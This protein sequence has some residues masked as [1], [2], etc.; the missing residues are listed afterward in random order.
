[1]SGRRRSRIAREHP[2]GTDQ[3]SE[4]LG[5]A[6]GLARTSGGITVPLP[7]HHRRPL[8]NVMRAPCAAPPSWRQQSWPSGCPSRP[9]PPV[10]PPPPRPHRLPPTR[11]VPRP[12]PPT[13]GPAPG[14]S[15][16]RAAGPRT[17]SR[18]CGRSCTPASAARRRGC[19]CPTRSAA[20]PLVVADV[21]VAQRTSGSTM[22]DRHRPRG[23]LRRPDLGHHAG[24]RLAVSD[25]IAFTVTALSDVAVSFYLPQPTGPATYHQQG[26]QTN[27]VAAGDV[28][29]NATLS[30]AATTGSYSFLTNLD[31]QN[32]AA[33]GRGRH[34]RRVDHRRRRLRAGQQPPLAQ[35]PG[36]AAVRQPAAPSACSTRAS[37]AT[38]CSADGAGQSALNRFDRDVLGQP[39][40]R[41]V[42]FSDDPINDLGSANPAQRRPAHRRPTA[43]DLPRAPGGGCR[44]CARR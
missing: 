14:R 44:S 9:P 31:V 2:P 12:P 32:A 15:R 5:A 30:G 42:I 27:Y 13:A 29:G 38:S 28:S 11:P 10:R 25:S 18:H 22:N 40:V 33:A 17:T 8:C 41:W 37:A 1:M 19:S 26:T 16:R 34:A 24:R 3:S 23:D 43:A 7:P 36:R 35:R 20:T 21:H 4:L 6:R 39:G